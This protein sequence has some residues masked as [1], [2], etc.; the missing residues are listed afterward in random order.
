MRTAKSIQNSKRENRIYVAGGSTFGVV[1]GGSR[2]IRLDG[3]LGCTTPVCWQD[4]KLT[5]PCS[6]GINHL[7][8][9]PSLFAGVR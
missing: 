9:G 6:S 1:T 2:I 7:S 3:C 5:Y 8:S 4:G